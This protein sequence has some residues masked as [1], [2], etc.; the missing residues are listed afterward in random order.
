MDLLDWLSE[1]LQC[2]YL[3]DL[4]HVS[5]NAAQ[6][7]KI[8]TLPE[9]EYSLEEYNKAVRTKVLDNDAAFETVQAAKEAIVEHLSK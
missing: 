9:A 2:Q 4:P 1:L 7:E 5:A 3:S 8:L 6:R